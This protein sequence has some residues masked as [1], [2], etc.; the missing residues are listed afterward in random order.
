MGVA[1]GGR[2]PKNKSGN[3][4][5]RRHFSIHGQQF[6]AAGV[7]RGQHHAFETRPQIF[8]RRQVE[9]GADLLADKFFGFIIFREAGQYL[10]VLPSPKSIS[11]RRMRSAFGGVRQAG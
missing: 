7:L 4:A 11:R 5:A 2:S 6:H 3:Q 9:H 8:A 10:A 1:R